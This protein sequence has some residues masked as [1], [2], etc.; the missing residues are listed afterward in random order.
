MF[1]LNSIHQFLQFLEKFLKYFAVVLACQTY[2][3]ANLS[4]TCKCVR[5]LILWEGTHLSRNFGC[6]I[7]QNM[8]QNQSICNTMWKMMESTQL[9]SK[10]VVYTKE[11]IC[12][13]HTS[14]AGSICHM[15][16]CFYIRAIF[17]CTRQIIKYQFDRI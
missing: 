9:M 15:L 2:R 6:I 1:D 5:I 3:T 10:R 11:C 4:V 7:A 12:E 8:K 14:H 17:V 13:S 16:S